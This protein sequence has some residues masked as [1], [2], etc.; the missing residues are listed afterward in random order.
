MCEEC[1]HNPCIPACPNYE[2]PI[3]YECDGCGE[4]I[5]A[6]DTVYVVNLDREYHFCDCCIYKTEA[7]IPEPDNDD[8][9]YESWRDRKWEQEHDV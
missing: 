2:P 1:R 5:C 8:S 4:A 3:V 6:G 7:E 9:I